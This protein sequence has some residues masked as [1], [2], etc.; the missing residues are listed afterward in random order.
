MVRVIWRDNHSKA[1]L[2]DSQQVFYTAHDARVRIKLCCFVPAALH[3]CGQ[4]QA[5][6]GINHR[7]VKRASC[8]MSPTLIMQRVAKCDEERTRFLLRDAAI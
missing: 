8:P 5:R 1:N 7:R 2:G 3:N 6:N 4:P